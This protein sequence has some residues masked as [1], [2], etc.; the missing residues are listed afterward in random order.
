[1]TH[2]LHACILYLF[3]VFLDSKDDNIHPLTKQLVESELGSILDGKESI[4]EYVNFYQTNASSLKQKLFSAKVIRLSSSRT[5]LAVNLIL[6]VDLNGVPLQDSIDAC[7]FLSNTAGCEDAVTS[8]KAKAAQAYP[9]SA[10][11]NPDLLKSVESFE[12][13]EED[14]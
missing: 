10:F 9:L 6:S 13:K 3:L 11:F 1:M 14:L 8:F 2:I 12:S 4:Q 7:R 5:D